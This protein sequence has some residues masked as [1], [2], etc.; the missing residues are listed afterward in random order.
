[1]HRARDDATHL[2]GPRPPNTYIGDA[3][4]NVAFVS[5]SLADVTA[6]NSK[7]RGQTFSIGTSMATGGAINLANA[8]AAHVPGDDRMW[9]DAFDDASTVYMTYHDLASGA[10]HVQASTDGGATYNAAFGE[11]ID[12]N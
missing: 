2:N 7:D 9:I 3:I 1:P 10:I 11:A 4:P 12:A 8:G 6:V 5:L